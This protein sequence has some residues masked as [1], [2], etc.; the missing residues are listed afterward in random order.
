MSDENRSSNVAEFTVS[1]ISYAVKASIEDQ[2]GY[3]RVRGE[4]GRV[5]RPASGHIYL[6]LKDEKS[7]LS[8]VVWR[9]VAGRLKVKP[10]QGLEV[11]ATGKLTTFPGQSKYQMVIDHMEPAGAGA[12]MAL[13]EERKKKL[14]A[15]GLFAA[16][17]KKPLPHLPRVIGVVTSPTGAVIRDILHRVQDRFPFMCW[18]GRYGC[19]GR[20]ARRKWLR[21]LMASTHCRK[22]GQCR[23]RTF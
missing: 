1:E 15:E 6:D 12:L 21:P 20:A 13:L 18:S 4:L 14:A 5:S 10:E 22:V 2:F 23:V 7:V 3:V 19:R 9:G 8:G 11:V 16:E 17:R